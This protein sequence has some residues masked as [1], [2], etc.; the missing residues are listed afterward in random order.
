MDTKLKGVW[1]KIKDFF[2]NMSTRVRIILAAAVV[3]IIAAAAAVAL[4]S[5][6]RPYETLFTDL[7]TDE[8]SAVPGGMCPLACRHPWKPKAFGPGPEVT[9]SCEAP[10]VCAG[11]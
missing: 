5:N 3:L 9:G 4:W 1:E 6:N 7:T 2:K 10:H 8:A 11:N